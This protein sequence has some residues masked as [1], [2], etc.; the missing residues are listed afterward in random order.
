MN[1]PQL[2]ALM[3]GANMMEIKLE[4][5]LLFLALNYGKLFLML[6]VS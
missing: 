1:G 5:R 3:V 2:L 6:D 4:T